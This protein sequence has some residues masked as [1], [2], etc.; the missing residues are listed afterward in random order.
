MQLFIKARNVSLPIKAIDPLGAS[1]SSHATKFI[2]S[3]RTIWAAACS[4]FHDSMFSTGQP[5]QPI[6][7]SGL[8]L[9]YSGQFVSVPMK[10]WYCSGT[11]GELTQA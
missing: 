10:I 3:L 6:S 4:L 1:G 11:V 2:V 7:R 5:L 8:Y 9:F